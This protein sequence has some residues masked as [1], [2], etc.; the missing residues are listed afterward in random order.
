MA[1]GIQMLRVLFI[2]FV[3]TPLEYEGFETLNHA[4][5]PTFGNFRNSPPFQ[6]GQ[7]IHLSASTSCFQHDRVDL[8]PQVGRG[9]PLCLS[10]RKRYVFVFF[11]S[12]I[13][14]PNYMY[15]FDEKGTLPTSCF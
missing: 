3:F 1:E 6:L 5:I 10:P 13:S 8:P 7:E 14:L 4:I 9:G 11:R 15:V 2:G 12:F